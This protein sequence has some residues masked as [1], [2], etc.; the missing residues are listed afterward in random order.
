MIKFKIPL[1][2]SV[3]L[4]G[5]S[6]VYKP[7]ATS[8]LPDKSS[9][10]GLI[11]G[12]DTTE[13][14][15]LINQPLPVIEPLLEINKT[16]DRPVVSEAHQIFVLSVPFMVQAPWANWDMPYQ[17]AC[18][19]AS[20]IMVAEYMAG[21]KK[22]RLAAPE[23]DKLILELLKWEEQHGYKIDLT[24]QEV[25]E[26]LNKRYGIK[27]QV[28]PYDIAVIRREL[29]DGRPVI[30]PAAGR[31]LK[32]PYFR[33]PGPLY[34]M[35]VVRGYAGDEIIVN[36]PGTKRGENYRYQTAILNQAVHDWNGGEVIE[37]EK[38]MVTIESVK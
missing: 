27:A 24:A 18:E 17:E 23:A 10:S 15:E 29:L 4:V 7:S 33:Q 5:L 36:D 3:I 13:V 35:L 6:C 14:A 2:L 22:M 20:I 30:L 8:L 28:V 25:A 12:G 16:D 38:L 26:V 9:E 32:N 1:I 31:L 37:G 19:E 21:N 11:S 34:H